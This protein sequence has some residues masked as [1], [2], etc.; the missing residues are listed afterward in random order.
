M[1]RYQKPLLSL[2]VLLLCMSLLVSCGGNAE[3]AVATFGDYEVLYGELRYLVLTQKDQMKSTYG[4]TIFDRA[5]SAELYREELE[6]AVLEKLK[7]NYVVLAACKHYLPDLEIDSETVTE[8]VDELIDAEMELLGGDRDAYFEA[9]ERYYMSE[10]FIRFTYAVAI[11]EELL[12]DE[13]AA[14]DEIENL[15]ADQENIAFRDWILA[16]NGVYV[17][18]LFIRNDAGE[19]VEANRQKAENA[20]QALADGSIAVNSAVGSASYNED[21][22]NAAPYYLVRDVYE[23]AMETAA[24]ALTKPGDVSEVVE[25]SEGFYVFIRME[26]PEHRAL[27]QKLTALLASHQWSRTEEIVATFRESVSFEWTDYGR[28]LDWLTIE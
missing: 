9:S 10:S 28:E 4:A 1:K 20:R 25:T 22:A 23:D 24:L 27:D 26:D 8:R 16:G 3:P 18:H 17:Q 5:E 12:V 15:F 6:G 13:L 7:S 21:T 11:M 2:L 14:R 19:D